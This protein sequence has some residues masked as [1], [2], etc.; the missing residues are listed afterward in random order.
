[1]LTRS[2]TSSMG[3]WS[4][5]WTTV[6]STICSPHPGPAGHTVPPLFRGALSGPGWDPRRRPPTASKACLLPP[7]ASCQQSSF[8]ADPG[9]KARLGLC[10][11]AG[12]VPASA[13]WGRSPASGDLLLHSGHVVLALVHDC[14]LLQWVFTGTQPEFASLH[15]SPDLT[16]SHTYPRRRCFKSGRTQKP[17]PVPLF[18][19]WLGL[20]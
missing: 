19:A 11:R 6:L 7:K 4:E 3:T 20:A 17:L 1:M 15:F 9:E 16:S 2:L 13:E 12:K 5:V 18:D 10:A 8:R 14:A